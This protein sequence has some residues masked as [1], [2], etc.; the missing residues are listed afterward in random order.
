MWPRTAFVE[1]RLWTWEVVTG[2]D[3]VLDPPTLRKRF[4]EDFPSVAQS[5]SEG[6]CTAEPVFRE[7]V[8]FNSA[9]KIRAKALIAGAACAKAAGTAASRFWITAGCTSSCSLKEGFA[10]G[11]RN[12]SI[13][14]KKACR[15]VSGGLTFFSG[16]TTCFRG[17]RNGTARLWT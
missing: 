13:I 14:I 3:G 9:R 11:A 8:S 7:K 4:A 6:S 15:N 5:C 12:L 16:T 10:T 1:A 2:F 17:Q